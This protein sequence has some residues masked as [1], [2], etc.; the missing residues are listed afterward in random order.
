[1][2]SRSDLQDS[3]SAELYS[4]EGLNAESRC[5]STLLTA[6]GD[7]LLDCPGAAPVIAGQRAPP[8]A[9]AVYFPRQD[10]LDRLLHSGLAGRH[11]RLSTELSSQYG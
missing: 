10:P 5:T 11:S 9:D 3:L 2:I 1:M 6:G 7:R 4:T 8:L